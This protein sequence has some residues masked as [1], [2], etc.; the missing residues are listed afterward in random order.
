MVNGMVLLH[1]GKVRQK[2]G[3]FVRN[4]AAYLA[5]QTM[6]RQVTAAE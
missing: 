6:A 2:P 4:A 3:I 5:G 1:W